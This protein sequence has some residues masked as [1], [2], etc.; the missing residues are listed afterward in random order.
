MASTANHVRS[1]EA[2]RI[3]RK[4][5]FI[6][7]ITII[8]FTLS[9]FIGYWLYVFFF[10]HI[11]AFDSVGVVT[12]FGNVSSVNTPGLY[13]GY[14]Y[15]IDVMKKFVVTLNTDYKMNIVFKTRDRYFMQTNMYI[16]NYIDCPKFPKEEYDR[17]IIDIYSKFYAIEGSEKDLP[18]EGMIFKYIPQIMTKHGST[19][20]AAETQTYKLIELFPKIKADLQEKVGK[21]IKIENIRLDNPVMKENNMEWIHSLTGIICSRI[22][23]IVAW[24]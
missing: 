5:N 23:R 16:D 12:R 15:P 24:I 19:L 4:T 7:M 14:P 13:V 10:G 8:G 21:Y 1:I 6:F 22:Y 20:L 9:S 17:C 2:E 18:E 3:A 11:V